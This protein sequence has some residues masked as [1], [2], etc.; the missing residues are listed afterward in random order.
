MSSTH[1]PASQGAELKR[2]LTVSGAGSTLLQTVISKVVQ[3]NTLRYQGG[4]STLPRRPGEGNAFYSNRRAASTTGADHVADTGTA[5]N[6]AGTYSQA[7]FT[8]RTLLGTVTITRQLVAKGRSYGDVVAKELMGKQEDVLEVQESTIFCGNNAADA[9]QPD[10][11]ITLVGA[12]SGQTIANTTAN[13]GD[14]L[15]LSKLDAAV[16]QVKGSANSADLYIYASQAGKRLIQNAL[17][18][19]QQFTD[20]TMIDAGF[21]VQSYNGIP[22]IKSTGLTDTMTWNGSSPKVTA[23]T[24]GTTT[25]I[26][27]ANTQYVFIAELTP[28]TVMPLAQTTS[29]NQS[30]D[31][32]TDYSVVLD[33]PK[34][35]SVLGGLLP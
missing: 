14:A 32:F 21:I 34:G 6:D 18:A 19:Q 24:G 4:V 16:D 27:V 11:L 5:N 10:G 9:N 23:F 13:A 30:I 2:A 3:L 15:V 25:A 17:Q 20:R 28:L 33:N 26:V 22:V 8:Y 29:Q 35:A 1:V 12:V 7:T 31:M